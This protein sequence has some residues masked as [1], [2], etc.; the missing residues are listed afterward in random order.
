VLSTEYYS[1]GTV[2]NDLKGKSLISR[3]GDAWLQGAEVR[4]YSCSSV[5]T[6]LV[7]QI[8]GDAPPGTSL[9]VWIGQE[10][11]GAWRIS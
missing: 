2:R 8:L 1:C 11:K 9:A 6:A 3:Y 7:V 5:E 10:F 4:G